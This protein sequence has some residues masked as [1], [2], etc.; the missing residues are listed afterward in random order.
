MQI[1][2][3]QQFKQTFIVSNQIWNIKCLKYV[4][5]LF[6]TYLTYVCQFGWIPQDVRVHFV[7]TDL[8]TQTG[9]ESK[10]LAKTGPE[11]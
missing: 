3:F 10:Q 9:Y 2:K 1:I 8:I 5:H 11:E 4:Y 7:N 6:L